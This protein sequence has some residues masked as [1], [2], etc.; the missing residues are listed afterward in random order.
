[1]LDPD[2]AFNRR[3]LPANFGIRPGR[4]VAQEILYIVDLNKVGAL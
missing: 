3:M 4:A 2:M 1:M